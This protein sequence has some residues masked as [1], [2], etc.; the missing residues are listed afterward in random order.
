MKYRLN[1][2]MFDLTDD[3]VD[4]IVIAYLKNCIETIGEPFNSE[5]RKYRKSLVRIHNYI[6][7]CD[8]HIK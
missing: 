5:E 6:T 7:T 2:V 3:E 8:K 4:D 1:D